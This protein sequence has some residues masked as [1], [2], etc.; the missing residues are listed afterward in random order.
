MIVVDD[1]IATGLTDLAAVRAMRAR[2]AA[3]IVVAVPVGPAESVARV[4]EEADEVVCHTIP[5]DLIGV[6]RWYRDFSPVSDEEVLALL[7]EAARAARAG[8]RTAPAGSVITAAPRQ[9]PPRT[10]QPATGGDPA[11]RRRPRRWRCR[12]TAS[13]SRAT[14]GCRPPPAAS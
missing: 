6:G 4:G 7:A 12:S 5:R 14:C 1:G 3:R 11:S 10:C 9:T 13:R 8:D 2:G